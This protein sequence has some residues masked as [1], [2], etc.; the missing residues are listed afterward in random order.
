MQNQ[1]P[2]K[3]FKFKLFS[4][5]ILRCKQD[6]F[7]MEEQS[8][9]YINM[10]RN[11]CVGKP[12]EPRS[13][14]FQ[15]NILTQGLLA[16]LYGLELNNCYFS[17]LMEALV[18]LM[19]ILDT[20]NSKLLQAR[21]LCLLISWSVLSLNTW[22]YHVNEYFWNENVKKRTELCPLNSCN[23]TDFNGFVFS[24]AVYPYNLT[25]TLLP[26]EGDDSLLVKVIWLHPGSCTERLLGFSFPLRALKLSD[27]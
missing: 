27:S 22:L 18:S 3:T 23:R 8:M 1:Q 20:N 2:L 19:Q 12:L 16:I 10:Y 25:N 24:P 15:V 13:P 14:L 17:K 21:H 6:L 4:H 11:N 9:F 7:V 5:L 26:A